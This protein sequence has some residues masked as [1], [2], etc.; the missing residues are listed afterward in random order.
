MTERLEGKGAVKTIEKAV[1]QKKIDDKKRKPWEEKETFRIV[2]QGKSI[3]FEKTRAEVI[4]AIYET[5]R[6]FHGRG[7]V[8]FNEFLNYLG[9]DS[10]PEGDE[11]GW[12]IYIGEAIY[13]YTWIDFGLKE[14]YDEPWVTEIYM[15]IYPHFFEEEECEN[16]L[17]EG[18]KKYLS[19]G[20]KD[21]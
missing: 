4:E 18:C 2:F 21:N 1:E 11:R 12:E 13:G 9:L 7:I 14:C 5:N 6:Y 8:T 17:N 20:K 10:V 19:D 3:Q 16:E 15:P